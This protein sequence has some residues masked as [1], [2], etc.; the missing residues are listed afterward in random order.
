MK[1]TEIL[2]H[3]THKN[4]LSCMSQN[5]RLFNV[6]N[7]SVRNFQIFLLMYTG[8]L[9]ELQRCVSGKGRGCERIHQTGGVRVRSVK[10]DHSSTCFGLSPIYAVN[11]HRW[12]I[13][14]MLNVLCL[15]QFKC[16]RFQTNYMTFLTGVKLRRSCRNGLHYWPILESNSA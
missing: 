12:D 13:A 1:Q 14:V 8:S 11:L 6:S 15:C 10:S 3:A 7:L 2:T 4:G 16:V 5:F 9:N